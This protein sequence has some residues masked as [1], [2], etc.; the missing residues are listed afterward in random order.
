MHI[1]ME[2]T[3]IRKISFVSSTWCTVVHVDEHTASVHQDEVCKSTHYYLD[4]PIH[5]WIRDIKFTSVTLT[6]AATDFVIN[7]VIPYQIPAYFMTNNGRQLV[8]KFFAGVTVLLGV[9]NLT[10]TVYHTQTIGQVE[11]FNWTIV[12]RLQ[13]YVE[14]HQANG[15]RYVKLLMYAYNVQVRSS[16]DKTPFSVVQC[17]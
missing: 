11:C 1:A 6:N 10:M 14:E 3:V 15:G 13:Q 16:T 5:K 12:V 7:L 4:I 17:C 2:K 8:S 9:R